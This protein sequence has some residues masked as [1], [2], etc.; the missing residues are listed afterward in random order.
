MIQVGYLPQLKDV[1]QELCAA[2]SLLEEVGVLAAVS[3]RINNF[4]PWV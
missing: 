3:Y 1:I 4:Q 2:I